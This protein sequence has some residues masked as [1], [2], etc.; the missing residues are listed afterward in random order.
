MPDARRARGWP[1]LI[2]E[3]CG[4]VRDTQDVATSTSCKRQ[5]RRVAA[6]EPER[7]QP[8]LTR[9]KRRGRDE[10]RTPTLCG[11]SLASCTPSASAK[12]TETHVL[13]PQLV[14]MLSAAQTAATFS[15]ESIVISST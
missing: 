7:G 3:A 1:Q 5:S 12:P 15:G 10:D 6:P 2:I 8:P 14:A 13:Q 9:P 11:S 4:C